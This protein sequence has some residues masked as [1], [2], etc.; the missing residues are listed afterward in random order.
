MS[1]SGCVRSADQKK[2]GSEDGG[3]E[4]IRTPDP[5]TASLVLSQLS[6]SPTRGIT[7]PG[8]AEGCQGWYRGL[9]LVPGAG[10]EP[11]RP[12]G[13]GVLSATRLPLLHPGSFYRSACAL[14]APWLTCIVQPSDPW[15]THGAL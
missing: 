14:R 1:R 12:Y 3:A 9:V 4:G 5:K 6:Y 10:F 2:C 8:G 7:L 13:H 15:P 11:A